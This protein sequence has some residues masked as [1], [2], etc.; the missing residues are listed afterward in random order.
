MFVPAYD[1]AWAAVAPYVAPYA[2]APESEPME[3]DGNSSPGSSFGDFAPTSRNEPMEEDKTADVPP[4]E[5]FE[6]DSEFPE[7]PDDAFRFARTGDDALLRAPLYTASAYLVRFASNYVEKRI[8]RRLEAASI[9][10]ARQLIRAAAGEGIAGGFRGNLFELLMHRKLQQP[11]A[12]FKVRCLSPGATKHEAR[13]TLLHSAEEVKV[14]DN[15]KYIQYEWSVYCRPLKKN[16]AG[17][18]AV[19]PRKVRRL[20]GTYFILLTCCDDCSVCAACFPNDGEQ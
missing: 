12:E 15:W 9:D 11:N 4:V 3:D 18:D 16:F 17:V 1:D 20:D 5:A 7:E 19:I 2:T 13:V 14:F 10:D 8:S 6:L